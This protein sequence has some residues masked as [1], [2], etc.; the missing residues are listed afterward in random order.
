MAQIGTRLLVGFLSQMS[1]PLRREATSVIQRNY[2]N[3]NR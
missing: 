2:H 1:L 3:E